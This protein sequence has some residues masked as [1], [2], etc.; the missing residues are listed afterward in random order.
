VAGD[1]ERF[2]TM[3]FLITNATDS[4]DALDY[5]ARF[6]DAYIR[7]ITLRSRYERNQ[8]SENLIPGFDV[9]IDFAHH[10]Y[11]PYNPPTRIVNAEF[12]DVS[13]FRLELRGIGSGECMINEIQIST[14]SDGRFDF[15][16][17]FHK[18]ANSACGKRRVTLFYFQKAIFAET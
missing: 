5:F 11:A 1:I 2:L 3:K 9:S 17:E 8:D 15:Q 14:S 10:S 12:L 7:Q 6:H 4:A 18:L 16:V 13:D